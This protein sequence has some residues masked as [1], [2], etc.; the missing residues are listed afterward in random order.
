MRKAFGSTYYRQ[1][2]LSIAIACT[3]PL[4][5]ATTKPYVTIASSINLAKA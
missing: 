2:L 4:L 1:A 3:E 5:L